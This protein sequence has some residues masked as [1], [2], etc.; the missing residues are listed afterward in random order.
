MSDYCPHCGRGGPLLPDLQSG[1][2]PMV[3]SH[4]MTIETIQWL[5]TNP[6]WFVLD[7]PIEALALDRVRLE[8]DDA[9]AIV[10]VERAGEVVAGSHASVVAR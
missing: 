10:T 8:V 6:R 4:N 5:G 1:S 9:Q 7:E 2:Q 3:L